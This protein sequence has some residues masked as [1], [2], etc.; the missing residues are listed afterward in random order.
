[1][2][3]V[4]AAREP[5]DQVPTLGWTAKR[6]KHAQTRRR[7]SRWALA[8]FLNRPTRTANAARGLTPWDS[9]LRADAEFGRHLARHPSATCASLAIVA[10]PSFGPHA[11]V[12]HSSDGCRVEEDGRLKLNRHPWPSADSTHIL[13]PYCSTMRLQIERPSPVPV[14]SL[15]V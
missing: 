4:A 12:L 2:S 7:D 9:Q 3:D 11:I 5:S 15:A 13:P 14:Y 1:M 8:I 10:Q 6:P